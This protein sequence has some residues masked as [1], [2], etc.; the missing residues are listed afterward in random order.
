MVKCNSLWVPATVIEFS[1]L[2]FIISPCFVISD[3]CCDPCE[4]LLCPF[5]QL[6]GFLEP[7]SSKVFSKNISINLIYILFRIVVS[8]ICSTC[9]Q[10][11]TGSLAVTSYACCRSFSS[12]ISTKI[13]C[14]NIVCILCSSL[15]PSIL[16]THFQ[17]KS[18]VPA[19]S[20]P[21]ILVMLEMR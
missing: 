3:D 2:A 12:T 6:C 10:I 5:I 21:V 7:A 13:L 20:S 1:S 4:I 19:D 8:C 17:E 15:L 9:K 11:S 18:L 14:C 16:K